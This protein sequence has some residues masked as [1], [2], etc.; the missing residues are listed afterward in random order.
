MTT[1]R[2]GPQ[3]RML[4]GTDEANGTLQLFDGYGHLLGR[5]V[6]DSLVTRRGRI[7]QVRGRKL[8]RHAINENTPE[9]GNL[10]ILT[11]FTVLM[12]SDG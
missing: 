6:D 10:F 1:F 3:R 2:N 12:L 5:L 7:L 11:M 9:N 4:C 8:S